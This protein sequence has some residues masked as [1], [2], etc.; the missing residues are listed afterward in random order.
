MAVDSESCFN[1]VGLLLVWLLLLLALDVSLRDMV[2]AKLGSRSRDSLLPVS[3]FSL[4]LLD[5]SLLLDFFF[6]NSDVSVST[7]GVALDPER[8]RFPLG[9][10]SSK[11]AELDEVAP[12]TEV[13]SSCSSIG[14]SGS[15]ASSSPPD[16]S[17]SWQRRILKRKKKKKIGHNNTF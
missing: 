10:L 17:I 6:G 14:I 7:D 8:F 15:S 9:K 2:T 3:T 12:E 4:D 16:T 13:L 1:L 5:T 11:L